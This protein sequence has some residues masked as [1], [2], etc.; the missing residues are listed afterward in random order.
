MAG[1]PRASGASSMDAPGAV[2][3]GGPELDERDCRH[4]LEW[5]RVRHGGTGGGRCRPQ[6]ANDRWP[7][8]RGVRGAKHV[9]LWL[10]ERPSV[11]GTATHASPLNALPPN[12]RVKLARELPSLLW[13]L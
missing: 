10:R 11:C 9:H 4:E 5:K 2:F 12:S 8:S 1:A 13:T 6:A 7:V 3:R